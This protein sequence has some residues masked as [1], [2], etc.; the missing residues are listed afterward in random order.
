M[1]IVIEV[2]INKHPKREGQGNSR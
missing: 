2:T 1:I